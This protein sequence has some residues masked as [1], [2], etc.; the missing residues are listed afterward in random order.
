MSKKVLLAGVAALLFAGS[1]SAAD[2]NITV[3]DNIAQVCKLT[4]DGSANHSYNVDMTKDGS[5][6]VAAQL[7]C[8]VPYS[9][10]VQAANGGFLS[11]KAGVSGYTGGTDE[12]E[13]TVD[14][15]GAVAFNSNDLTTPR[16][17]RNNATPTFGETGDIT[18]DWTGATDLYAGRYEDVLTFTV[19][20]TP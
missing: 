1:A 13:Y 6:A 16:T 10:S 15:N 5:R 3:Y 17:L 12:V 14:V 18:I 2:H 19:T 11:D 8:N 4:L 20:P 9:L 7:D